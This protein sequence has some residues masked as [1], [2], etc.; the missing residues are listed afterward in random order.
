MDPWVHGH[1]EHDA[2]ANARC[3]SRADDIRCR[4]AVADDFGQPLLTICSSKAL[5]TLNQNKVD[6]VKGPV[7]HELWEFQMVMA[8]LPD[9]PNQKCSPQRCA[10]LYSRPKICEAE[11]GGSGVLS[12]WLGGGRVAAESCLLGEG[13]G[14]GGGGG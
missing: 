6:F 13:G 1:Y 2:R 4:F 14:G 3:Q 8:R 9:M 10:K 5:F 12:H 7:V 11:Q